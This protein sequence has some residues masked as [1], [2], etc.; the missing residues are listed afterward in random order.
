MYT[1]VYYIANQY[2]TISH[3]T[4]N[5]INE[6]TKAFQPTLRK[7]QPTCMRSIFIKAKPLIEPMVSTLPPATTI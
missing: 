7:Y 6:P 2:D 5:P 3:K 1:Y 4:N